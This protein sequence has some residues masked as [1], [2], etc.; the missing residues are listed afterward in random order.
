M[1]SLEPEGTHG[2]ACGKALSEPLSLVSEDQFLV[3]A[4]FRRNQKV[5]GS[6]RLHSCLATEA[7]FAGEMG[8]A[9]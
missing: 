4:A 6:H 3:S 5:E 7:L 2:I 1:C 8:A 9:L